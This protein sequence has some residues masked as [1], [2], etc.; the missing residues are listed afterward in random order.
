MVDLV[1]P[2]IAYLAAVVQVE[3]TVVLDGLL[4]LGDVTAATEAL[5]NLDR[6]SRVL[7]YKV[8]DQLFDFRQIRLL[9]GGYVKAQ[10]LQL[11]TT[12]EDGLNLLE[13]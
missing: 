7:I 10:L 13:F 1:F 11:L 3:S 5:L 4:E 9:I 12:L 8:H 6:S 2:E